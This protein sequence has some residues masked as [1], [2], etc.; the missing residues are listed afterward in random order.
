[1]RTSIGRPIATI[2][3]L[4]ALGGCGAP[5]LSR[6]G[7]G[8]AAASGPPAGGRSGSAAGPTFA[9]PDAGG[10]DAPVAQAP[11]AACGLQRHRLDRLIPQLM[12]VLD[13]S[14]SMNLGLDFGSNT[15]WQETTAAVQYVLRQTRGTV[16]W[17]L[18]NFPTITG[19]DVLP[20][21]EVPI[22]DDWLP[23]SNAIAAGSPAQSGAGTPTSDAVAAAAAYLETL[24]TPNPKYIVLATDGLPTCP[25]TDLALALQD[26]IDQMAAAAAAGFPSF[27]IGIA[28]AGTEADVALGQM[29]VAGGRPR[30]GMPAYY[31]VGDR[32]SLVTAL[33]QITRSVET[34][35]FPL[36]RQAP[37]PEDV[38]VNVDGTR[39]MRDATRMN[40]WDYGPDNKVV[41]LYGAACE[42]VKG[43][44]VLSLEIIFGCPQQPI[45]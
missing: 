41:N 2:L 5:K 6:E 25:Q 18:K 19:C 38:A 4:V 30:T 35:T 42:K 40:G 43:G 3:V 29:A 32:Q 11:D 10:H 23:V 1:M 27:V 44:G 14:G 34:C 21:V 31:P 17:G 26:T 28:T 33:G 24:T 9:L 12:L 16:A 8:G 22:S 20:Q 7:L 39:I 45:L 36:D 15:R 37:S 13:R